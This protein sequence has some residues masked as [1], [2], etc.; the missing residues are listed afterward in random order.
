MNSK[1]KYKINFGLLTILSEATIQQELLMTAAG[2]K[3][4]AIGHEFLGKHV[5]YEISL[6]NIQLIGAV[7][8]NSL[9]GKYLQF[10]LDL[11]ICELSGLYCMCV[12]V[13]KSL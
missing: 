4:I 2:H 6:T 7:T 9:T 1:L 13:E 3:L 11:E 5:F 8:Y 12:P 10:C